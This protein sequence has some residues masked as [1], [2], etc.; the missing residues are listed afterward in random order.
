MGSR[1]S[2]DFS[3]T[4]TRPSTSRSTLY[5][6]SACTPW[7]VMDFDRCRNDLAGH[8]ISP[9]SGLLGSMVVPVQR[10]PLVKLRGRRA[11]VV[12]RPRS[13]GHLARLPGPPVN[14]ADDSLPDRLPATPQWP[15]PGGT[16]K[17]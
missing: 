10:P 9:C 6:A 11:F 17:G 12:H 14:A 3:S 1:L 2:T 4:T 7:Q 8:R 16:T 15:M 13:S 5:E